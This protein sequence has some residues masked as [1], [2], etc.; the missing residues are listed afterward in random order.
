[1]SHKNQT[2]HVVTPNGERYERIYPHHWTPEQILAHLAIQKRVF[3]FNVAVTRQ[4]KSFGEDAPPGLTTVPHG[5]PRSGFAFDHPST[6]VVIGEPD[7][8]GGFREINRIKEPPKKAEETPQG[9]V[10]N[11]AL[12]PTS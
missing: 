8:A 6:V 4:D 9:G 7:G 3:G 11:E 1:M 5:D 10:E 2:V 12:G